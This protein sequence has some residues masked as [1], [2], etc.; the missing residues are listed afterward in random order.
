MPAATEKVIDALGT[1]RR[2]TSVARVRIRPGTGKLTINDR[3]LDDYFTIVQDRNAVV[4]PL[5]HAGVRA[6][7][8]VII[9]AHGGG[10]TGQAGACM[11]GIARA[12]MRYDS[13]L[14]DKLREKHFLTRDARMKERKKFGLH[15]ARR[16]T[17]FSKR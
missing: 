10:N 15:G 1:G 6:S 8:D 2:K 5:E 4:A 12:L 3:E 11:Q 17:Q 9:L 7:V 14:S 13:D 16:G